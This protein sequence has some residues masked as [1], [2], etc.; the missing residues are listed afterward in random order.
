M[1]S[2]N[3]K[4]K[5][6]TQV[7]QFLYDWKLKLAILSAVVIPSV[8]ATGSFYK[9]EIRLNEKNQQTE[10]RISRLELDTQRTFADKPT[11]T[12]LQDDVAK[13]R[14]DTA[15]IKALLKHKLR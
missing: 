12:K 14:E 9:M 15:E 1:S 3:T 11:L 10:S 7:S 2:E 13:L 8:T 6:G 5:P 4:L